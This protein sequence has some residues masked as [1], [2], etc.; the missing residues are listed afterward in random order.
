[1]DALLAVAIITLPLEASAP[2]CRRCRR[3]ASACRCRGNNNNDN[4]SSSEVL[5]ADPPLHLIPVSHSGPTAPAVQT[6]AEGQTKTAQSRTQLAQKNEHS[7]LFRSRYC[8]CWFLLFSPIFFFLSPP[9]VFCSYH[10]FLC[11]WKC[12]QGRTE[13]R[14]KQA[15]CFDRITRGNRQLGHDA[16]N[17]LLLLSAGLTPLNLEVASR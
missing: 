5:A 1:M 15:C 10:I 4:G 2:D 13:D 17:L 16:A 11:C 6:S 14:L 3:V 12:L 8:R 9:F 7:F